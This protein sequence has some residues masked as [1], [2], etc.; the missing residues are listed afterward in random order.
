M[1]NVFNKFMQFPILFDDDVRGDFTKF[2]NDLIAPNTIVLSTGDYGLCIFQNILPF[3]D[4]GIHICFWDRRFKGR[5]TE[6]KM[7]LRWIFDKMKLE[8]AT[9]FVP[10]T[11]RATISFI[12]SLGFKKEGIRRKDYLFNGRLLDTI[13][14][15]ITKEDVLNLNDKGKEE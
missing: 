11:V 5:D 3:R 2:A 13:W 14:F 4:V 12:Y 9:I 8:R 7:A 6:C 10:D 1:V 15:G